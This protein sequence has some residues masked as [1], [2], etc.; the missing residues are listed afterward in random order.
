[1]TIFLAI[2]PGSTCGM[3]AYQVRP[4]EMFRPFDVRVYQMSDTECVDWC[5]QYLTNSWVVFMERF[6]ITA[7]TPQLSAEGTHK[8]LDVIGTVKNLCRWSGAGFLFQT[9]SDAANLVDNDQLRHLELWQTNADHARDAI[10][11][12][13]YGL[14]NHSAERVSQDL[15]QRLTA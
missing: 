8:T 11:H 14:A 13:V 9:K 6:F 5:H 12:L 4:E 1:M 10:R 2:D 7:K 15:K 3:A